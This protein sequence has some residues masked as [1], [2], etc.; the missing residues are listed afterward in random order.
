M[1]INL[2]NLMKGMDLQGIFVLAALVSLV[3]GIIIWDLY[4]K[5]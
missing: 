2:D 3:M 4:K 1:K 5:D